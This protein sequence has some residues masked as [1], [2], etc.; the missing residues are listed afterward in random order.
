MKLKLKISINNQEPTSVNLTFILRTFDSVLE[1][2]LE[3]Y[4]KREY[5]NSISSLNET[6]TVIIIL[7]FIVLFHTNFMQ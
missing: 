6:K 7:G 1:G 5:F 2:M 3:K 4:L